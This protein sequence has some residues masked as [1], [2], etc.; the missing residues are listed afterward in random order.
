[1][2]CFLDLR[3]RNFT[4]MA[5]ILGNLEFMVALLGLRQ[6]SAPLGAGMAQGG[7]RRS[8][9]SGHFPVQPQSDPKFFRQ[10]SFPSG[11]ILAYKLSFG[12]VLD[13][14]D[15]K[16]EKV[17]PEKFQSK[18]FCD[19]QLSQQKFSGKKNF[20]AKESSG[21]RILWPAFRRTDYDGEVS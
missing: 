2:G 16:P 5:F 1:M 21:F 11:K 10:F 8:T 7:T 14:L 19:F 15:F 9:L 17:R 13:F 3:R 20:A 4:E 18:L 12:I 6:A